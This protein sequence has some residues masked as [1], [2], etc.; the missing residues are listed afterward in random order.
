[1]VRPADAIDHAAEA[2]EHDKD[3]T[4]GKAAEHDK[5]EKAGTAAE[6]DKD[7]KV[8][9]APVHEKDEKAGKAAEHDMDETAGKAAEH[10]KEAMAGKVA[11]V[12]RVSD[13]Q[14][15]NLPVRIVVE[16]PEGEL[17]IGESIRVAIVVEEQKSALQVPTAAIL[18]LG[19][20]PVL[21]VVRD[22]KTVILHPE[23]GPS[24]KG[25]TAVSGTDLKEGEPVI[26]E[27]GYN[28]PAETP[29]LLAGAG[30]KEGAEAHGDG[31]KAATKAHEPDE[32]AAGK[33]HDADEK[34][35]PKP[36]EPSE[37]A[38]PKPHERGEKAAAEANR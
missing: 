26:V 34:A 15:G 10:D 2:A 33:A 28:L 23:V 3:E 4:T 17:T 30:E 25:W 35:A 20:G 11:F 16:N 1:L 27:G 18:D 22:G 13:P 29:V 9:K 21:S 32:K 31:E 14:T 38:A 19:E 7:E 8:A 5:D 36:H 6:H 12:G 24:H 37:K